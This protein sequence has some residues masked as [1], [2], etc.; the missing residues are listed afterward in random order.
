MFRAALKSPFSPSPLP[1][2]VNRVILQLR[3]EKWKDTTLDP[4]P[5]QSKE[6]WLHVITFFFFFDV[7]RA[8]VHLFTVNKM[9]REQRSVGASRKWYS[10][11]S[12]SWLGKTHGRQLLLRVFLPRSRFAYLHR[13]RHHYGALV[14]IWRNSEPAVPRSS[15]N[16][17]SAQTEV[18]AGRVNQWHRECL[19][20]DM[21][22]CP[23][24][25][26]CRPDLL[27]PWWFLRRL[28]RAGQQ[29]SV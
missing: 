1:L 5:L 14:S 11:W 21:T 19:F 15:K 12:P 9:L 27:Q 28:L 8:T 16:E 18:G 25:L 20:P 10:V 7:L 13:V 4:L 17:L 6:I 23:S 3:D 26:P 22:H 2:P 29:Q 24:P